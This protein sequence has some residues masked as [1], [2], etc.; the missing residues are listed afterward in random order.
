MTTTITVHYET[1]LGNQTTIEHT[2]D[3]VA[4]GKEDVI[5]ALSLLPRGGVVTS[6]EV[7]HDG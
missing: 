6:V 7:S 4:V 2:T 5:T 3:T 1:P